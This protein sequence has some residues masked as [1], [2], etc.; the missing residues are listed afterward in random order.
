MK[1]NEMTGDILDAPVK[2][3]RQFERAGA[4]CCQ[5]SA[6]LRENNQV[7]GFH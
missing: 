7:A 4:A 3:Y 1:E 6:S 2:L 5:P